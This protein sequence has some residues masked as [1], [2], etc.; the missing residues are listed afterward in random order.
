M[1]KFSFDTSNQAV[2]QLTEWLGIGETYLAGFLGVSSK[3][4]ADWKKRGTGDLPP[5]AQ[6]LVR[7]YEVVSYLKKRH[8]DLPQREYKGLLENGRLVIDPEDDE[9]GSFSLLN[10]I[11]EEPNA[12]V[13]AS[14]VDQVVGEYQ[15]ILSATGK[16]REANRTV[17]HAL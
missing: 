4:L 1:D 5:K 3:S 10:F 11:L 16:I 13:W 2:T 14:C 15:N 17:R 7:L 9:E 6:R 12:K 8:P